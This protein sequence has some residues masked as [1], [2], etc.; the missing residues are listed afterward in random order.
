MSSSIYLFFFSLANLDEAACKQ[1][2][3]EFVNQN[4]CYGKKPANEMNIQKALGLTALH[5]SMVTLVQ[6]I[7]YILKLGGVSKVW[8][9]VE[10]IQMGIAF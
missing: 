5:V 7:K 1:A 6:E 4:C 10:N 8:I 2:M 9:F 3:I